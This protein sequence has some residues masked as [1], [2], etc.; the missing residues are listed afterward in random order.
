MQPDD[1]EVLGEN[2]FDEFA[3]HFSGE[4]PP[5][6][7]V[8]TSRYPSSK[9]MAFLEIIVDL[10]PNCEYRKRGAVPIKEVVKAA[11]KRDFT[12][13]MVFTEKSKQV[14]GLWMIKLPEGPTARFKLT[15]VVMPKK[16]KSHGRKTSHRPELILNNFSTRLGNR[17]GRFLGCLV[18]HDPQFKG[19]QV[20]TMHNQRDFIFFRCAVVLRPHLGEGLRVE[21]HLRGPATE[22]SPSS[23]SHE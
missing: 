11:S 23:P 12:M 21:H 17:V 4:R 6:I 18:P 13:L 2:S 1:D 10:F 15:N 19:R 8:T 16:L 22:S 9:L 7:V 3:E 5:R 14:H 20:V